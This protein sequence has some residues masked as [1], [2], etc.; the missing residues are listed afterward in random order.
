[1]ALNV[2]PRMLGSESESSDTPPMSV[3]SFHQPV[4]S[5]QA[6]MLRGSLAGTTGENVEQVEI[7]FHADLA[8]DRVI[9]AWAATVERTIALRTGFVILDGEPSGVQTIAVETPVLTDLRIPPSWETWLAN[10]RQ[11]PFPLAGGLPWR[12]VLWP[13]ARKLIWTFHHALLDG[14]SITKILRAF[15]ARLSGMDEPGDLVLEIGSPRAPAEIAAAAE[16]HRRAFAE[17]EASQPEFPADQDNLPAHVHRSLGPEAAA[18][19][20]A[21]ALEMEVTAPTLLTWAWGQAVACAAGTDVVAV[22]QVRSGPPRPGQ[23]G[24]FMNTVPLVIHRAARGPAAPVLQ[25]FRKRLLAMRSIE[26]VAPQDLPADI[27]QETGGPWPG[28][29]V[30]VERGTLHHEVGKSEVIESMTLHELGGEPLLASAWIHPDLRLEV[31]VNGTSYGPRA[32]ESLLDHWAAI[33]LAI[34]EE[35][36]AETDD[37]TALPASMRET[38]LRQET[39]G[40]PVAHLHLATA[41]RDASETFAGRCALWT[42]E[43]SVSY[44][45]LAAQVDHLAACL[46]EAGIRRGQTVASILWTRKHLAV[47]LLALARLGAI[48]VP[49]DPALPKNRLLSI[50]EDAGPSIILSDDPGACTDL[51]MPCITIDGKTGKTCTA[52]FPNDPRETLSILYTSGS[53]GQPKGVMMVHGGVTNEARGIARLAGIGPDDRVLQ[54]ASPGFDASL[55]ELLATLLSGATLVPRPENLA[56]DLDEFQRFIRSA[57]IT[58]L[59]LS[60]AHWAAWCAWMVSENTTIPETVRTT[61]IGGERSSAAAL[62]DWFAAGGRQHLLINTYGPTE[63]SIVATAELIRGD[64]NEFGDPAIGR[65]LPG[66]FARAGDSS[67]RAMPHG[68]AGELWLGGICVGDGYWQRPDLTATAFHFMDGRYWYRTGD[69]GCWDDT[70]KLRFLG[71]QDDQLK[72]RGNRVEPNEVIRVLEAFPGVSAAH[73]GPVPGH[74]GSNLLAA[75]VRWNAPPAEGWPGLLAKHASAFLPTAAIPTRWAAVDDFK[76]TE[77]GKLDRRRLP[78]PILTASTHVSSAPPA[79]PTEKRLVILWS[80]LLGVRTIGRDESFFELGGHSLAALQLFAS[81][82]R[83]WNIRIPMA[84]LIQAPTP[85]MLGEVIDA[86]CAGQGCLKSPPSIIIPVRPDGHLPPLFC[87]H[88]GD[89]G[90]F[91]YRDLAEQLPAGLPLLAIESPALAAVEEASPVPVAETAAAYVAALREHQPHGP[92]HLA[93]Y[94]YGGL[95][96]F[97]IARKL[98]AE[99]ETVAFAGLFDTINPA[100]TIREYTLMERAKVFWDAQDHPNWFRRA[101]SMLVRAREGIA[102]HFRVKE[103]IRSARA[104]GRS[105]PHS[106]LRM[107]KVREAHWASMNAYQPTPIDCHITLFKSRATDDKFDIPDDYGWN[108]LVKSMD[109]VEVEGKHLTM[110]APRHVGALAREISRR[111]PDV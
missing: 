26:N 93:G 70:G 69:R 94:S 54:F 74:G 75:W 38:L 18:R 17:I 107:L 111:L 10:D 72:I 23:A 42:P 79:T 62:K 30:M 1:M 83:E 36:S 20:E 108:Q 39:G 78:E 5:L 65:P 67:G 24:F 53:T 87:I 76:L 105:E 82:A 61:I 46:H 98:I 4:S 40:E 12:A 8:M 84:I 90:V 47:V 101:A 86:E 43:D 22:G 51:S 95:L 15:Q 31:E 102:T 106:H 58:V 81:I 3:P 52:E 45:E 89:G 96:V 37:L 103:E 88:G 49:L 41:W 29:I 19:I 80:A 68:A 63:A 92:F 34:A 109:I 27:F 13:E 99:G 60:T 57:A 14:R 11:V 28:G 33:V 59:D 104:P 2:P 25:E 48:N 91:F 73:A 44:S 35:K 100:A 85:R 110:F 56:A 21:A 64:W 6:A 97:E 77:R 7:D 9:S 55:E 50:L 71:R 66:V 16:F 32:A